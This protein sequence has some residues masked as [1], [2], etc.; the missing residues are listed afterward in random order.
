MKTESGN[1]E[2]GDMTVWETEITSQAAVAAVADDT[3]TKDYF[4]KNDVLQ[5]IA[6]CAHSASACSTD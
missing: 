3:D 2:T 5:H 4:K 1:M 6:Q